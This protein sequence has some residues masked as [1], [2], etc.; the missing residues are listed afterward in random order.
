MDV[1]FFSFLFVIATSIWMAVDA[2]S[3]KIPISGKDYN[4]N[5]GAIAWFLSGV[6]L[7]IATVPYYLYRR[8]SFQSSPPV[9]SVAGEIRELK[10]LLDDGAITEQ[11]FQAQKAR[12]LKVQ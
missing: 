12:L 5:T 9:A 7:W 2:E 11:E 10:G 1:F 8:N 4:V 3:N 6:L